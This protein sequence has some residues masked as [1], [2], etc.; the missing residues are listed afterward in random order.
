MLKQ[1]YTIAVIGD[2]QRTSRLERMLL[3]REQN[4][5]ERELLVQHLCRANFDVFVHLGDMVVSGASQQAWQEFDNLFAPIFARDITCIPLW[6]NHEYWGNARRRQAHL[7]VR[8]PQLLH[9]PWQAQIHRHLGLVFLDSNIAH[10]SRTAWTQQARWCESTLREM[11][12]NPSVAAILVFS[13]HPPFSNSAA[14]KRA[15]H[16]EARFLPAFF[17]SHKTRAFISGHVHG[18]ERFVMNGKTFIVSGGGGG[19][20]LP[21][22]RVEQQRYVDQFTGTAPRPFHYL[23]IHAEAKQLRV[24][25]LGMAKGQSRVGMIE[26]FRLDGV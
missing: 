15:Q 10:Y 24:E 25:V 18:Y 1:K 16:L 13:H 19:P 9:T 26:E 3:R 7:Q 8:F 21:L 11:T 12:E 23:L 17:A 22:R 2:T 6:G 20:R 4:D 14:L 5:D